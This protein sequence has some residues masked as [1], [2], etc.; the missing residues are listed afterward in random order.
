MKDLDSLAPKL[1]GQIVKE[2]D[3]IAEAGITQ[4]LSQGGQQIPKI[5]PQII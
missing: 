1:V 5:T 3:K 2:I 4:I